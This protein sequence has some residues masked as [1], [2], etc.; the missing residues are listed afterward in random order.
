[1]FLRSNKGQ[2]TLEYAI[3]IAVIAAGLIA[4]G[5]YVKRAAEGRMKESSDNIG[6]QYEAVGTTGTYIDT[7]AS[8]S[9][10][11]RTQSDIQATQR[12]KQTREVKKETLPEYK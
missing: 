11:L 8:E 9:K 6:E 3:L 2:N 7:T 12:Q 5:N 1:M 10:S 4:I